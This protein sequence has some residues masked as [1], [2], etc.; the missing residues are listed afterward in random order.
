MNPEE[1]CEQ[2]EI[3]AIL[4]AEIGVLTPVC[5]QTLE[6]CFV[7]DLPHHAIA[8]ALD[9]SVATV[10]SRVH[11]AKAMLRRAMTLRIQTSKDMDELEE[12]SVK[13][14][15]GRHDHIHTNS[16]FSPAITGKPAHAMQ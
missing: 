16:A 15:T 4:H 10:K 8:K 6:M 7:R 1:L 12:I 3:A 2:S 11:R 14:P 13:K 5:K 9:T